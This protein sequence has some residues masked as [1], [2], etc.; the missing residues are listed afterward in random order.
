MFEIAGSHLLQWFVAV[1]LSIPHFIR[2]HEAENSGGLGTRLVK[3]F[4]FRSIG[5]GGGYLPFG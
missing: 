3:A 4:M 1:G 5:D 2:L